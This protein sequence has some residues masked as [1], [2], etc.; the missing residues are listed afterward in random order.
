MSPG[1]SVILLGTGTPN[2]EPDRSGPAVAVV[3]GDKAYL[4]DFGPGVVR[5]AVAA[6]L[7]VTGLNTALLTHLH[8]DH[9]A[10]YPDLILTPWTLGREEPLSVY[11]PRGLA[12]MTENILAAYAEDVR[13]R[14][15]GPEPANRTG[16]RVEA[17]EIEPGVFLRDDE[18]EIEAF[19]VDHGSWPAFGYKFTARDRTVV[20]SGDTAPCAL[21][22]EKARGCD[23][24]VHEV[25][26]AAG[27]ER[28]P[29]AWR[30]YHKKMHTSAVELGEIARKTGP[31][32]LVLYH[33]LFWGAT[34]EELV[35]EV[36]SGYD[37]EVVSG[38][39]LEIF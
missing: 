29:P 2:A 11:G 30:R 35:E 21:L 26:S 17:R 9:T 3:V 12:A 33:Q 18:I 28:R 16:H 24:L 1:I 7:D 34:E 38:R 19:G 10:G 5:R 6:G 23:L 15:E 27:L 8:S 37:G 32:L 13:E 39:D 22:V 4:V 31:R 25:Y 14:V 20:V 36:R